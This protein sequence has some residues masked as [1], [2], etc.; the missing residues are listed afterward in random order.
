MYYDSSDQSRDPYEDMVT[1]LM[2]ENGIDPADDDNDDN[3]YGCRPNEDTLGPCIGLTATLEDMEA[4]R[5]FED[6]CA[7]REFDSMR[8]KGF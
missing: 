7:Q 5:D 1:M 4:M 8:E 6:I 2:I 3:D